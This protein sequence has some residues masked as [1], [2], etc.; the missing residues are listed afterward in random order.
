MFDLRE[1]SCIGSCVDLIDPVVCRVFGRFDQF[2]IVALHVINAL[3]NPVH[4]LLNR[5]RQI[6]QNRWAARARNREKVGK[7]RGLQP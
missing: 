2:E 1:Q 6:A 4:M 3:G 5:R 7:P